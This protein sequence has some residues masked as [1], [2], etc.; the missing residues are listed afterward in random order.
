MGCRHPDF[1]KLLPTKAGSP[2]LLLA[3]AAASEDVSVGRSRSQVQINDRSGDFATVSRLKLDSKALGALFCQRHEHRSRRDQLSCGGGDGGFA[4][5]FHFW[6]KE[7]HLAVRGW[8]PRKPQRYGPLP[9]ACLPASDMRRR[10]RGG[11]LRAMVD[12]TPAFGSRTFSVR[13]PGD[14][15]RRRGLHEEIRRPRPFGCT[16]S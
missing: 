14:A 3:R 4:A 15:S 9:T 13:T 10:A 6:C 12:Q 2:M 7:C 16:V 1:R 8:R 5:L 11:G